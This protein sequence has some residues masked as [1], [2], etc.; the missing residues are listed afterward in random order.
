MTVNWKQIVSELEKGIEIVPNIENWKIETSGYLEILNL[1]KNSNFNLESIKWI[2]YYPGKHFSKN[3]EDTVANQLMINPLRS[4]ISRID[5]GFCAPWHWDVDDNE[6]EYLKKGEL[7]RYSCFLQ[8]PTPGHIL[9]IKEKYYYN[10]S[11][12]EMIRWDNY[13]D[14]HAATNFGLSPKFMYHIIGYS[15]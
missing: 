7:I 5:P 6:S 9:Q 1:W 3:V 4:W 11:L 15:L 14:W 10:N 13:K 8:D 2:N 12:G